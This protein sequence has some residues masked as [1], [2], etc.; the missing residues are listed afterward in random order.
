ML[1]GEGNKAFKR[2]QEE[3]LRNTH[4]QSIFAWEGV[5][6][7]NSGLLARSPDNF[8][9]LR[10]RGAGNSIER[11][12][13]HMITNVGISLA[14]HLRPWVPGIYLAVLNCTYYIQ[15][16]DKLQFVGIFV[17]KVDEEG[18]YARTESRNCDLWRS[19]PIKYDFL[20]FGDGPVS[21]SV[22]NALDSREWGTGSVP[23]PFYGFH[24]AILS[25]RR[26]PHLD[27]FPTAAAISDEPTRQIGLHDGASG[28][29]CEVVTGPQLSSS[30]PIRIKLAFYKNFVPHCIV[31]CGHPFEGEAGHWSGDAGW[32]T[33]LKAW[34]RRPNS[35]ADG[36]SLALL[37][38]RHKDRGVV[39][40][41]HFYPK[42]NIVVLRPSRN[43]RDFKSIMD[44]SPGAIIDAIL[45]ATDEKA[46]TEQQIRIEVIPPDRCRALAPWNV[47]IYLDC[48]STRGDDNP[49]FKGELTF[50]NEELSGV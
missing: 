16:P 45:V 7:S 25:G 40:G 26:P 38:D 13:P 24:V 20:G 4:D 30:S 2:L 41:D 15:R 11:T 35:G 28:V 6:R 43:R 34:K 1:Y 21:I 32:K 44:F 37:R 9:R 50:Y 19:G 48:V 10:L 39:V 27:V 46:R 47:R 23:P 5:D 12:G 36:H 42:A 8:P 31:Y 14:V 49:G 22:L 33:A 3:I 29:V 18:R 17:R